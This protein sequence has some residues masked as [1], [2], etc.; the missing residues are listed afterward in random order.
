[1]ATFSIFNNDFMT[2]NQYD[3]MFIILKF[4]PMFF[5]RN[6]GTFGMGF[7]SWSIVFRLSR[8]S[9]AKSLPNGRDGNANGAAQQQHSQ[10]EWGRRV[11]IWPLAASFGP[12]AKGPWAV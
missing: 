4:I 6:F 11:R 7:Q 9:L 10:L 2:I 12:F 8:Q 1:L 3:K 5:H